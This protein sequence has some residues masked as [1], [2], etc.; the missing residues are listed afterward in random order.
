MAHVLEFVFY[1]ANILP[2]LILQL[3]CCQPEH[4]QVFEDAFSFNVHFLFS[5]VLVNSIV[6]SSE[7]VD[8]VPRQL[9]QGKMRHFLLPELL[10]I[11]VFAEYDPTL[12]ASQIRKIFVIHVDQNHRA[13]E[14]ADG[15]DD[16]PV[17]MVVGRGF[18]R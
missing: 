10:V 14:G 8:R 16:D 2:I 17:L 6:V 12:S 5:K 9:V 7:V 3:I 4:V 1:L 13:N 11:L 18:Y 15:V